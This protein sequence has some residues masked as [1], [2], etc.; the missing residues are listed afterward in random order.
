MTTLVNLFV[1]WSSLLDISLVI[2]EICVHCLVKQTIW[3][4]F[5]AQNF[6]CHRSGLW[7]DFLLLI[8]DGNH[9]WPLVLRS[10]RRKQFEC[11]VQTHPEM[12]LSI[13]TAGEACWNWAT[14]YTVF[15]SNICQVS[16]QKWTILYAIV[17][18]SVRV[19]TTQTLESVLE[20][21]I[22][23]PNAN[24]DGG[25]CFCWHAGSALTFKE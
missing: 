24:F 10:K 17:C 21:H 8:I 13:L 4:G 7:F 16:D 19:N 20:F 18:L 1:I 11:R 14:H 3:L 23:E 5:W 9:I 6:V 15:T 12:S 2:E 22:S 25:S